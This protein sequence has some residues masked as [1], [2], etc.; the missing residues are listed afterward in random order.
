MSIVRQIFAACLAVGMSAG[1]AMAQTGP[2]V[3]ELYTSQGC[4]SCPPADALLTE[5]A[6][7]SDVIPLALHVDYW[8]Y[9]GWK[10]EF[11]SPE[12]TARQRAYARSGKRKMIY[13]PQMIIGGETAIAGHHPMAV[14]D[15][16]ARE[17]NKPPSVSIT[18]RAQDG[19]VQITLKAL[20]P[21]P[22]GAVV[23]VVRY[24]PLARVEIGRGENAGRTIDYTNTVSSWKEVTTWNGKRDKSF[25]LSYSGSDPAVLIIQED[26]H[27]R[28]LAAAA[29]R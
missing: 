9:L 24:K 23:H 5:L 3:I 18:T 10:D 26:G 19:K 21:I 1:G 4:S 16:V 15:A 20:R 17:L 2:V 25:E 6:T 8:D 29:L 28:I 7:R 27:R 12:F 22:R 13:T 14:M 11:A